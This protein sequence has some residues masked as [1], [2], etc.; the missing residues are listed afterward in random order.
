VAE[1]NLRWKADTAEAIAKTEALKRVVA[2]VGGSSTTSAIKN[3]ASSWKILV[4]AIAAASVAVL[5]LTGNLGALA[6][7]IPV[8]TIALTALLAPFTTLAAIVVGFIPPLTLLVGLLGGLGVA[9][10]LAGIRALKGGGIF[11]GLGEIVDKVEGQFHDLVYTLGKDFLPIF[12]MLAKSASTALTYLNQIAH[13]PLKE[14]FQSLSTTGVAGFQKFLDKIGHIIAKPIR[15]AFQ[16]AFGKSST[17]RDALVDDWND[18]VNFFI[19]HK[20]VLLPVQKWFGKQDFTAVGYRWASELAGAFMTGLGMALR[21]AL[22]SRGGKMIL[23]GALAGGAIGGL[24]TGGNIM[25]IALGTAIGAGVGV[26]LNHY[27]P[28][29]TAAATRTFHKVGALLKQALGPKLW[30]DIISLAQSFWD[31]MKSIGSVIQKQIWPVV[32]RVWDA[33]GGW[34]SVAVLVAAALRT[35]IGPIVLAAKLVRALYDAWLRVLHAVG[36]VAGAISSIIGGLNTAVGL[37]TRLASAISSGLGGS[38]GSPGG[39][40]GPSTGKGHAA[41][42]VGGIVTRPTWALIGEAGPEAV[43]P[44]NRTAGSR[45]LS[46]VGAQQINL[47]LDGKVVASVLV[48]AEKTYRR[49]NAGRSLFAV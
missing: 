41:G 8:I 45:A 17:L 11:K 25:G 32:K 36:S 4:P 22:A 1:A 16:V 12:T 33:L 26:T 43:V 37:A 5:G 46:G 21:K 31:T 2:S 28:R 14:A 15:L 24:L 30:N 29:I 49:Q 39:N 40:R 44:L 38:P 34:H 19:G 48:D 20:G 13:L 3:L 9:F 27:W 7:L 35:V 10:G 6:P 18:I 47:I 42:A 23:G